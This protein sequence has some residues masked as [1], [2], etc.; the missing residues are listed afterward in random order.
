MK[1]FGL[2]VLFYTFAFAHDPNK[3]ETPSWTYYSRFSFVQDVDQQVG[4]RLLRSFK[5]DKRES[6]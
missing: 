2:I 1:Y 6:I 4:G 5:K 3:D